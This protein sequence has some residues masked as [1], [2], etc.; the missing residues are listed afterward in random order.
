LKSEEVSTFFALLSDAMTF[1]AL[2][3]RNEERRKLLV[4][5]SCWL[6]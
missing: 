6:S 5:L 1:P 4:Y 3:V 2:T